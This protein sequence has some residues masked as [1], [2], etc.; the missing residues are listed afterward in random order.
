MSQLYGMFRANSSVKGF[1]INI[2]A[3]FDK[4]CNQGFN[5]G[6]LISLLKQF[7]SKNLLDICYKYWEIIDFEQFR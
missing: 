4:L 5:K 2:N 1:F 6:H 3:L 7:E